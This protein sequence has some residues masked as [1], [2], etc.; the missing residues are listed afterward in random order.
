[1]RPE[2][3]AGAVC[4]VPDRGTRRHNKS[5]E[6]I[7]VEAKAAIAVEGAF[8]GAEGADERRQDPQHI[9]KTVLA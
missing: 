5:F 4:E 8:A 1:M 3:D 7:D 6:E 9:A 2:I